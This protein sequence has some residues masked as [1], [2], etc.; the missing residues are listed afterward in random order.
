MMCGFSIAENPINFPIFTYAITRYNTRN[1]SFI[2]SH[3]S[4]SF[5]GASPELFMVEIEYCFLL[6]LLNK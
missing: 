1:L 5:F 2:S 6:Y 3:F 4:S